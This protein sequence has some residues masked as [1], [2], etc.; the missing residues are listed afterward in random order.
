[1]SSDDPKWEKTASAYHRVETNQPPQDLI[2]S[3]LQS[4]EVLSFRP[5]L[6]NNALTY[7]GPYHTIH[8]FKQNR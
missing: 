5:S 6:D 7:I 1:L 4:T 8:L 3:Y 2:I